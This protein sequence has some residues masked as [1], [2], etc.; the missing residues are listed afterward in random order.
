[1]IM[2]VSSSVS[3]IAA[4]AA[5]A[6]TPPPIT[7]EGIVESSTLSFATNNIDDINMVQ[8]NTLIPYITSLIII[9]WCL[10]YLYCGCR[11]KGS[12]K[13]ARDRR[14]SANADDAPLTAAHPR[15][16]RATSSSGIFLCLWQHLSGCCIEIDF[17]LVSAESF[18]SS[19]GAVAAAAVQSWPQWLLTLQS[20]QELWKH[21]KW[22][23]SKLRHGK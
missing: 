18:R 3:S 9:Q 19:V 16:H 11:A 15:R 14:I 4:I 20:G 7:N 6:A 17:P 22:G 23:S 21:S 1:M 12:T 10:F 8:W 2:S 13:S 5:I